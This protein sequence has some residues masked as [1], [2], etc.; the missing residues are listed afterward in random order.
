MDRKKSVTSSLN[1]NLFSIQGVLSSVLVG[2]LG[3]GLLAGCTSQGGSWRCANQNIRP[4]ADTSRLVQNAEYLKRTG[5]LELALEELEEARLREPNNL[6]LLGL[7]IQTY[8]DLGDFDRAE[9]LYQQALSRDQHHP[10]L[11]NNR[12]FSL[13][14]Q[15]RLEEAEACFRKILS[16]QPD[17]HKARNNLGLTLC[18]QGREAEALATW[19]EALSDAAARGRLGQALAALGKEVPPSLDVALPRPAAPQPAPPRAAAPPAAVPKPIVTLGSP[20]D[21][22]KPEEIQKPVAATPPPLE[23]ASTPPSRSNHLVSQPEQPEPKKSTAPSETTPSPIRSASVRK[24]LHTGKAQAQISVSD[25]RPTVAPDDRRAISPG[26]L[27][28]LDLL[29][30]HIEIRNGNG[31]RNHARETRSL[32]SLEGFN[33]VNIGNHIDF[34]LEETV[35]AFRPEAARIVQ[36]LAQ[37]FFPGAKLEQGG[38]VSPEAAVRVSLGQD[39][40][41]E[42]YL[43]RKKHQSPVAASPYPAN[44]QAPKGATPKVSQTSTPTPA[45]SA[46]SASP[47]LQDLDQVGIEIKNGNGVQ[48]LARQFQ[49]RL[50]LEGYVVVG[51]GNHVDFG[52]QR[53]II[54]YRPD[55]VQVAQALAQEFFPAAILEPQGPGDLSA[56]AKVT[57]SLGHDLVPNQKQLAQAAP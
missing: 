36:V 55:A 22:R 56:E 35:I 42:Q 46:P 10:A 57:V 39:R 34:G 37:K 38:K 51:I 48:G 24:D 41:I 2:F 49:R 33:V 27:T 1:F 53:T 40:L 4:A 54:A 14:L 52:L 25:S 9:E 11:E 43:S 31:I 45:K 3:L 6:V 19:R 28:A 29:T 13:Y 7:L 20:P 15:D 30:T 32:L 12:C 47:A 23:K 17:N 21:T 18:R 26:N 44:H 50:A 16:R 5:R 8:E